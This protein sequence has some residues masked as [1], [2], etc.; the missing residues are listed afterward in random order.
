[1]DK[2]KI[3]KEKVRLPFLKRFFDIT[4]SL[5]AIVVLFGLYIIITSL[6]I[7][8]HLLRFSWPMPIYGEIRITT[9]RKF[10]LI[11]FNPFKP[12]VIRKYKKE[13]KYF[14]AKEQEKNH[15][16]LTIIG[17]VLQHVYL[18]EL[19]QLFLILIGRMTLVG[20]RPVNEKVYK[21][22]K[23][24]GINNKDVFRAG[25]TG[26]YQ[27]NKGVKGVD[28]HVYDGEYIEFVRNNPGWKVVL[29][30]ITILVRTVLIMMKAKGY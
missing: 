18:D 8:E 27:I 13:G 25:L 1:M 28:Q 14:Y 5:V 4:F 11:K 19:P 9:G 23:S 12:S 2:N 16:N 30:D 17:Y 15:R 20:P 6:L 7:I 29:L 26:T 24:Q 22:L 21:K 3:R 10:K